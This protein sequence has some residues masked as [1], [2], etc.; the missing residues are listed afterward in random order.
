MWQQLQQRISLWRGP[1]LITPA[2][3]GVIVALSS[4]GFLH[5]F[6]WAALDTWFRLRPQEPIDSRIAIVTIN[7]S[8]IKY[9]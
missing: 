2:V 4:A 5:L 3:T 1:L 8:D 7:E 9:V 6:E